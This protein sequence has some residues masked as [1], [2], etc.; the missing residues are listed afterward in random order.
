ME[1]IKK[2]D[3]D[4]IFRIERFRSINNAM[5]EQ[6]LNTYGHKNIAFRPKEPLFEDI[7]I[8]KK[9]FTQNIFFQL[10]YI[11]K[12][13]NLIFHKKDINHKNISR[14]RFDDR[15]DL[16]KFFERT[17]VKFFFDRYKEYFS[18]EM[19]EKWFGMLKDLPNSNN[20]IVLSDGR[21]EKIAMLMTYD[22]SDC[23]GNRVT[24]V[25]WIWVDENVGASERINIHHQLV[26]WLLEKSQ[27]LIQ[28]GVHIDNV[29]SQKY[30]MKLGFKP[31]C[32]HLFR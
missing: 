21:G 1:V 2:T 10:G 4:I 30:F 3:R 29:R 26:S 23:I 25:G 11:S 20:T 16:I 22:S 5:I 9:S 17:W 13:K 15:G 8:M 27:D 32:M 28:A 31:V 24:Q 19:K 6:A 7:N 14:Y 12:K 18:P